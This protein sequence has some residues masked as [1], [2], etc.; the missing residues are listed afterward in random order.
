MPTRVTVIIPTYNRAEILRKTLEGYAKQ[1]GNHRILEIIVVDD[2]SNDHTREVVAEAS[3]SQVPLRYCYQHNAG[4][5]AARNHA[6]REA[7]G[8]LL[9]FGDDDIIP[10][11]SLTAKHVRCHEI[12]PA[13]EVGILGYV[14]WL[15]DR[16]PTP[17][18]QW[19]SHYGPQFNFGYFT[20]KRELNFQHGY[21]CNT[22]VYGSFLAKCG[23]FSE[24]FKTYGYEDI[25]LSYRLSKHGYRILYSPDA[26]G[27]HN[28]YET[29]DDAL[30]RVEKLYK[31]WHEF[32]KTEA[33]ETFLRLWREGRTQAGKGNESVVKRVLRPI[34]NMMAP[35]LRSV[36]DTHMP[37]PNWIYEQIF[38]HYVT[39]FDKVVGLQ[40]VKDLTVM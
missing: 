23:I 16:K 39:P 13:E 5:A 34:K 30:I 10:S 36:V 24:N 20:A 19:S 28:K 11:P 37:L 7:K 18:M 2:G 38:Y 12:N 35:V 22:S 21:F 8:D 32:A 17:F 15:P 1:N 3:F 6:I 14:P 25:E 9:L 27:Y 33:G 4:L 31:S 26:I 40:G 29:F